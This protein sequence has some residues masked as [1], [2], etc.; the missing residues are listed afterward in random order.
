M[1]NSRHNCK[2]DNSTHELLQNGNGDGSDEAPE[3]VTLALWSASLPREQT[4]VVEAKKD[5]VCASSFQRDRS[6]EARHVHP[7]LPD[8]DDLATRLAGLR[9]S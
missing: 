6:Y 4:R 2:R 9:G 7:K 5:F 3:I 1:S 8:Y